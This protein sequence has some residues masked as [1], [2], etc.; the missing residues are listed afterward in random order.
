L[1][2]VLTVVAVVVA[3]NKLRNKVVV[4]LQSRQHLVQSLHTETLAARAA[5]VP[6]LKQAVAA[7][8]QAVLVLML[9]IK[10]AAQVARVQM[11]SH[12]G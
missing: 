10:L 12:L 2:K 5:V 4:H 9:E 8:E 6:G 7:G 3:Q 11:H 1:Q